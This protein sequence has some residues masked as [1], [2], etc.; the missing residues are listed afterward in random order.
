MILTSRELAGI[1][2][3]CIFAGWA[4]SVRGVRSSLGPLV[5]TLLSPKLLLLFTTI[6]GYNVAVVW[7]LWRIGY[8]APAMLYDTVLFIAVGGIGAISKAATRG[9]TYDRKFFAKTVLVNLELIAL[10]TLLSDLFP[11]SFV[12]E[13]LVVIPVMTFLAM[14]IAVAQYQEGAEQVHRLLTGVQGALGVLLLS[15][16]GWRVVTGIAQLLDPT[17]LF[18]LALP[19]IMSAT[20][21]PVLFLVCSAFAYEDAFLVVSFKSDNR[22][23]SRWKKL[24]LLLRFGLNLPAMQAFRRSPAIHRYAWLKTKEEARAV[25]KSWSGSFDDSLL[26]GA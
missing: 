10:V 26:E 7:G 14:L 25:L 15:Y 22:Q 6:I 9:V 18:E 17:V 11:F 12:V 23:L 24:R 20:F 16:V 21:V 3:L 1:L 8:W 5:K 4:L 2:W 19:V 13:F